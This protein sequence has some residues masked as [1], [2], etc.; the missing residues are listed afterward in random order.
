VL[1]LHLVIFAMMRIAYYLLI[2]VE[3]FSE[4]MITTGIC[5]SLDD[6]CMHARIHQFAM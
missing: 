3:T 5:F 1:R 6:S 2:L 4:D